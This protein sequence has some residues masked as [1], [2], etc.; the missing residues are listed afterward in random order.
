MD[1]KR[2]HIACFSKNNNTFPSLTL[3][4]QQW[5]TLSPIFE[6]VVL[7]SCCFTVGC[8]W[9]WRTW[10][11]LC[12]HSYSPTLS[13]LGRFK[14]AIHVFNINEWLWLHFGQR[15]NLFN[16]PL[17]K[18]A[19]LYQLLWWHRVPLQF[20]L[21]RVSVWCQWDIRK[22]PTHTS[23]VAC[24]YRF[25]QISLVRKVAPSEWSWVWALISLCQQHIQ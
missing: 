19:E 6:V 3:I 8:G 14:L 15:H 21:A 7:L 20:F 5:L 22:C 25:A 17:L 10:M 4:V 9:V 11:S 12:S 24:G 18:H 1:W 23:W 2:D 16:C 13:N